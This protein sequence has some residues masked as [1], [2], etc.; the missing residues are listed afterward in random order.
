[1][2]A[3]TGRVDNAQSASRPEPRRTGSDRTVPPPLLERLALELLRVLVLVFVPVVFI[4]IPGQVDGLVLPAQR[5]DRRLDGTHIDRSQQHHHINKL[6]LLHLAQR[7]RVDRPR[8]VRRPFGQL[9]A[10]SC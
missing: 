1:M 3:G 7:F 10:P 4:I 9:S 6:R 2:S 5:A 8:H